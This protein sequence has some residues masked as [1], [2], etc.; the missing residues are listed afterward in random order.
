M[1]AG[2]GHGTPLGDDGLGTPGPYILKV[3]ISSTREIAQFWGIVE[4]GKGASAGSRSTGP[5]GERRLHAARIPEMVT[6]TTQSAEPSQTAST[7][8]ARPWICTG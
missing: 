4:T 5:G 8:R 1:I 2:M 7:T 3:G 6:A